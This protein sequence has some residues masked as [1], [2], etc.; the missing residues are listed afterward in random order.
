MPLPV[1]RKGESGYGQL[2][3]I[4]IVSSQDVPP[5]IRT[6]RTIRHG[7]HHHRERVAEQAH[8]H[9]LAVRARAA[10]LLGRALESDPVRTRAIQVNRVLVRT[11]AVHDII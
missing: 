10:Q 9:D 5:C 11:L 1:V 2:L 7:Y 8:R 3:V 6:E 4:H